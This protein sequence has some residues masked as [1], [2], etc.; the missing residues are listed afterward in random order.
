MTSTGRLQGWDY[1]GNGYYFITFTT[2][3]YNKVF[4]EIVNGEVELNEFGKL[5]LD[6]W[7]KSFTIRKE[8]YC[9]GFVIMPDHIHAVLE[10]RKDEHGQT[11]N[12]HDRTVNSHG[13]VSLQES[14][15]QG[16][17]NKQHASDQ[18]LT[19]RPKSISSFIAC[20][21]AALINKINDFIDEYD[22]LKPYDI[23]RTK[24]Y[25][26]FNKENP[27]WQSNYHDRI[28]RGFDEYCRILTYIKNNPVNWEK[29]YVVD[30]MR[31]L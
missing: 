6:E 24:E 25:V 31:V 27:L 1:C 12:S 8:L 9:K 29:K 22:E 21:K 17:A 2:Y 13:R 11:V 20:Y 30:K 28:I 14:Q 3:E 4:G 18:G 7:E 23:F 16:R 19:R 10:I 5:A 15:S 26:K